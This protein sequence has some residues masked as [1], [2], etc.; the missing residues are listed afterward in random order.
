MSIFFG[1]IFYTREL[2]REIIIILEIIVSKILNIE[3]Y[4]WYHSNYKQ[5]SE[6][7]YGRWKGFNLKLRI[8]VKSNIFWIDLV[9]LR[10][11]ITSMIAR[12]YSVHQENNYAQKSFESPFFLISVVSLLVSTASFASFYPYLSILLNLPPPLLV[13]HAF[14]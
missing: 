12:K 13:N 9:T 5:L 6:D 1:E 8:F 7:L 3:E 11:L 14:I 10:N 2:E 4:H